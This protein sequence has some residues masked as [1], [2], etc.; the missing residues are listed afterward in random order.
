MVL[1]MNVQPGSGRIPW[2]NLKTNSGMHSLIWLK[3]AWVIPHMCKINPRVD[4][5]FK[6][7]FGS[8]DKYRAYLLVGILS[9]LS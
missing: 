3:G 7:L 8:K 6:K 5:A 2:R 4:F 9:V 1:Q